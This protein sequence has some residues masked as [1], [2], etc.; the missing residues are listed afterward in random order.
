MGFIQE[1]DGP[2][3]GFLLTLVVSGVH[4]STPRMKESEKRSGSFNMAR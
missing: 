4:E 1:I 2:G 3:I